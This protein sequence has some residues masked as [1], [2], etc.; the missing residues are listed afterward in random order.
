MDGGSTT[1]NQAGFVGQ[2]SLQRIQ[3]VALSGS[4]FVR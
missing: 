3:Q 1:A 4:T 2:R